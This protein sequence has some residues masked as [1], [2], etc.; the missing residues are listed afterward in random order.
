[1][2]E[3]KGVRPPVLSKQGASKEKFGNLT[4]KIQFEEVVMKIIVIGATGRI[5]SKIVEAFAPNH[6]IV[7]AGRS[8]ASVPVDYTRAD[9]VQ[10]MFQKVGRFDALICAAGGDSVF[11]HYNEIEESDY[12]YGFERKFLSQIRLI[13][14]GVPFCNDGG[15]ITITT[16]FLSHYP[17]PYS[18]GTGPLNAAVDSFVRGVAPLLPRGIRANVVSPA[19][20]V[21][22][23]QEGEGAVTAEQTARAY[24]ESV[25]GNISGKTL[26]VWGGLPLP[27]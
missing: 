2:G 25:E 11:K 17:N 18:L 7:D 20:I 3:T 23:G 8:N 9:S 27:D 1:L 19:P 13:K 26:R 21:E 14:L 15:S 10:E 16:G 5:G 4:R 24:V 22:P 6:E 12:L